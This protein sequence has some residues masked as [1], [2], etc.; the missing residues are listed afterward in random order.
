MTKAL[1]ELLA[2][3]RLLRSGRCKMEHSSAMLI[4]LPSHQLFD[5]SLHNV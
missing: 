1:Q 5:A 2:D 3:V 4:Y